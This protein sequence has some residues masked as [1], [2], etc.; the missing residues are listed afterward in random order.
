[1]SGLIEVLDGNAKG[2]KSQSFRERAVRHPQRLRNAPNHFD[3]SLRSLRLCVLCVE[4]AG[5]GS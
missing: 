1:M 4:N 5:A 2:A 3:F